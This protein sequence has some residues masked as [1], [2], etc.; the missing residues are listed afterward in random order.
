MEYSGL[1]G[2]LG[3]GLIKRFIKSGKKNPF[4]NE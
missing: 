1:I 4:F 2:V 3:K